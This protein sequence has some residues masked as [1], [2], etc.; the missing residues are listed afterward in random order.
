[1]IRDGNIIRINP[2]G[3]TTSRP[4]T[5]EER[6]RLAEAREENLRRRHESRAEENERRKADEQYLV[7]NQEQAARQLATERQAPERNNRSDYRGERRRKIKINAGAIVFVILMAAVVGISV[8]QISKNASSE[9]SS[10][11]NLPGYKE[12]ENGGGSLSSDETAGSGT[13]NPDGDGFTLFDTYTVSNGTVD[14]GNLVLVNY[15]HAYA[16][17]DTI[18]LTNVYENRTGDADK[19]RLKVSKSDIELTPEAFASLERLVV[20]LKTD[21]GTSDL[22]ITSG[23]RTVAE[24]QNL[25]SD[26][27]TTKG[28]DYVKAYVAD[29]TFSEHHTGLACDLTFYTFEGYSVPI[30]DYEYGSWVGENCMKEGFVRRYPDNKAD[31]TKI[32][33]E[34][35][36]FRYVGIPHAYAITAWGVC[37]EEYIEQIKAYTVDTKMLHVMQDMTVEDKNV[38]DIAAD[39]V[40]GGWL[41]Y[42][43]PASSADDNGTTDIP[44][45]RGKRY[46]DY[47]VSGTNDGGFI[48]TVTLG[49]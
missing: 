14:E 27:L 21:T 16:N 48:V 33:Y 5:D 20:R 35:W 23:H 10:K 47:E 49:G 11:G 26:F 18:K 25:Y 15:S 28:E 22:M 19:G 7:R 29:P 38:T 37:L 41:V 9:N 12:T 45:L 24:Q 30:P 44:V 4:L 40:S 43:V 3:T 34:P 32:S 36:H 42:Y 1:M 8:R 2:D 39:G 17:A 46:A 6:R 31:I 13:A